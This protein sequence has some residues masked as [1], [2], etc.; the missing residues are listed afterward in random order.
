MAENEHENQ[1]ESHLSSLKNRVK[2]HTRAMTGDTAQKIRAG[3]DHKKQDQ[4]KVW[5]ESKGAKL[6]KQDGEDAG[7]AISASA[8][9][10]MFVGKKGRGEYRDVDSGGVTQLLSNST[11]SRVERMRI[12]TKLR[13]S[14]KMRGEHLFG[15]GGSST[16]FS[17]YR[18][19]V[20]GDDIR[21]VDWNIFSRLGRPYLKQ[22]RHE[23]EMQIV[24]VVDG[25]N[26]MMFD[27]KF[28]R[29]KQ[30]ATAFGVM[31]LYSSEKVSAHVIGVDEGKQKKLKACTG[32][33]SMHK[34]FKYFEDLDGGGGEQLE[35][36]VERVLHTHRGKG[37]VF[38]M[39]DW[40][41]YGD[42]SGPMTRLASAGLEIMAMQVLSPVEI[43][44][45][46]EG[47]LR[48][49]DSE[50]AGTLDVSAAG[51]VVG[52][53]QEYRLKYEHYLENHCKLRGGRFAV[54]SSHDDLSYVLFDMLL[55]KG[56]VK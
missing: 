9:A 1:S 49:M 22:Y 34:L 3:V 25:S 11:L 51:D 45:D 55:R 2:K 53:Y 21:Y 10:G 24:L 12:V 36:G 15:K 29:A 4:R 31:G 50:G 6:R 13:K 30:L 16:E 54:T 40:L 7:T 47:D 33:G 39:S 14:N 35:E 42:V 43:D 18:N 56:W 32:R 38:I 27:G 26:S 41:S 8:K 28:E 44:P 46:L 23:E 19:Y 37:V 52:L 17:D 5:Q 48:F 20:E